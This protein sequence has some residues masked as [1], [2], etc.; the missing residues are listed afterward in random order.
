[1]A[2]GLPGKASLSTCIYYVG[3]TVSSNDHSLLCRVRIPFQMECS[4]SIS[5]GIFSRL[6]LKLN[7]GFLMS[8]FLTTQFIL[9]PRNT[10]DKSPVVIPLL[11][12]SAAP[13]WQK[14]YVHVVIL[15]TYSLDYFFFSKKSFLFDS[16]N[17]ENFF[18]TLL[19]QLFSTGLDV[20]STWFC[21]RVPEI[22][23]RSRL[24][25]PRRPAQG[26]R[27]PSGLSECD[28]IP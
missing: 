3:G 10:A 5:D 1:M 27:R 6:K 26:I 4:D 28:H 22:A 23:N 24:F 12:R 13:F 19:P 21:L 20:L 2:D 7:F 18:P 17:N 8:S 25:D 14:K 11:F 9:S 15:R 16:I